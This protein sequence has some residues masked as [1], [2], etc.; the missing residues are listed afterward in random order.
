MSA[1]SLLGVIATLALVLGL[2]TAALRLLRR[3]AASGGTGRGRLPM[4]VVQRVA[5]GPRQG[6]AVV[7]IG[8]RLLAVSL[9]EGGVR[10][11]AEL[12]DAERALLEA[13]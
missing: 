13:P 10:P 12:G 6:I 3:F 1:G 8:E 2:M 9:G 4:E 5:L 7:R 11:L